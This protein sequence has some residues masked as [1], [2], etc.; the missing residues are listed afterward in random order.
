[1]AVCCVAV[2]PAAAMAQEGARQFQ[3]HFSATHAGREVQLRFDFDWSPEGQVASGRTDPA[4]TVLNAQTVLKALPTTPLDRAD[5]WSSTFVAT[6]DRS[7]RPVRVEPWVTDSWPAG[8]EQKLVA[9]LK[10]LRFSKSS[11]PKRILLLEVMLKR[12]A[13][14]AG[15]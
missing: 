6:L 11:A 10:E 13:A 1:M 4:S 15:S 14:D 3:Q 9:Q 5:R 7:G 8:F 2:F 12:A